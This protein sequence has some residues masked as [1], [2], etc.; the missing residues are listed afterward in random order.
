MDLLDVEKI[1]NNFQTELTAD[2]R[3]DELSI[4]EKAMLAPITKHK[5]VARTTQYKS[6]LLKLEYTKKQKVKSKLVDSPVALSKTA[7]DEIM[8]NDEDIVS[9]TTCIE[10]IKVIL[11]YLEKVE[12]KY[13]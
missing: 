10:Q 2:I 1:I 4:K 12:K 9:I 7:R 5:W 6:T 3:M 11:E 13:Y 8:N